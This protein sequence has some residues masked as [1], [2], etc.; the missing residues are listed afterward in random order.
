MLIEGCRRHGEVMRLRGL[1]AGVG[2]IQRA[3]PTAQSL[4]GRD[5]RVLTQLWRNCLLYLGSLTISA[6]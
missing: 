2:G 5:V 6:Q 4:W 3:S 1:G